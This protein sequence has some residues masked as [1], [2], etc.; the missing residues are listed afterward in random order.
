MS[1]ELFENLE[2]KVQ[3]TIDTI[4]LLKMEVDELK[5]K[6]K[7][8]SDELANANESKIALI[9]ENNAIKSE[10]EKWQERLR[11]LLEKMDSVKQLD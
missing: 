8:L 5:E 9:E 6:N 3:Q 7:V 2:A 10:K 1:F 11:L 4:E